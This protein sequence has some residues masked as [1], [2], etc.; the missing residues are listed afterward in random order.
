MSSL[1]PIMETMTSWPEFN[2]S[3]LLKFSL[4]NWFTCFL[5]A[6]FRYTFARFVAECQSLICSRLR[7]FTI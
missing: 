1:G 5:F 4:E 7:R 3:Y 2:Y 6:I